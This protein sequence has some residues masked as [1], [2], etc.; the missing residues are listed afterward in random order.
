MEVNIGKCLCDTCRMIS[1]KGIF[2]F[3]LLFDVSLVT[4]RELEW[5]RSKQ[6]DIRRD[7]MDGT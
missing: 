7:E 4:S 2:L 1:Y 5:S 6:M 3:S